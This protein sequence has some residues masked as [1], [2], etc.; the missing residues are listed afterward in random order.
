MTAPFMRAYS[1]ACIKACHKRGAFAMGGM[2]A[3]IPVKTDAAANEKA[4]EKVRE[5]KRR[6]A[7]DGHDG[8]WVAH[9]GLVSIATEEFNKVLD[10]RPNQIDRLSDDIN[11][12]AEQLIEVPKGTITE[13]GLR[14]NIR[15]AIQYLE[16]WL[17]GL[18]CVPLY[19]LMEDA[20]TAEISRTQV[21]QWVR[22]ARGILVDGRKVTLALVRQFMQRE[23]ERIPARDHRAEAT[24]NFDSL[25]SGE[26]LEEFLTLKA[27]EMLD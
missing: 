25:I 18:G 2:A 27:Y 21:W 9:P 26:T 3:Y 8:T 19:N 16:A 17:G 1:L 5:D 22:Q 14:H 12:T 13:E 7:T 24:Q 10:R 15:V 4:M 6:E 23:L 11:V 20:A